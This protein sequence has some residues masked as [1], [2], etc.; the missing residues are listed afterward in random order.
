MPANA[1]FFDE[2]VELDGEVF[3]RLSPIKAMFDWGG[4]LETCGG[5]DVTGGGGGGTLTGVNGRSAFT[6]GDC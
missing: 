1:R 5:G 4:V 2:P 6:V 3:F